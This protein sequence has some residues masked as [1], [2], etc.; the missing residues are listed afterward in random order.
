MAKQLQCNSC[1]GIYP[2]TRGE[3]QVRYF[4]VCPKQIVDQPGET[5]EQN[6]VVKAATFKAVQNPRNENLIPH[7]DKAGEYVMISEGAGVTEI[8]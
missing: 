5:D 7:P 3:N 2:D 8:E 1:K 4:H 6:N